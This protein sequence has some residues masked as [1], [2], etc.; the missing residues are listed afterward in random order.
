MAARESCSVPATHSMAGKGKQKLASTKAATDALKEQI[1]SLDTRVERLN[2][3][4]P[5]VRCSAG[6]L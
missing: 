5:T 6:R 3:S 4:R 1:A 2:K